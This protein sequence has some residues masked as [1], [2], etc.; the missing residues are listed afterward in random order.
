M[1]PDQDTFALAAALVTAGYLD[2]AQLVLDYF[3]KPLNFTPEFGLWTACGRP[4]EPGDQGWDWF[5]R[6]L[7]QFE[8]VI[9]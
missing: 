1:R 2:S 3:D 7:E 4:G 9:A 5:T 8:E 6:K